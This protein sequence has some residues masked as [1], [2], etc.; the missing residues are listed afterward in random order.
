MKYW[1]FRKTATKKDTTKKHKPAEPVH[2]LHYRLSYECSNN[3]AFFFIKT[4]ITA[5]YYTGK[6]FFASVLTS[7]DAVCQLLSLDSCVE[8]LDL[9]GKIKI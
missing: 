2:F 5:V 1:A 6:D 8:I 4:E 3:E 7:Q 9:G